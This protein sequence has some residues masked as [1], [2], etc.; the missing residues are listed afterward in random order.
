MGLR[1]DIINKPKRLNL[2]DIKKITPVKPVEPEIKTPLPPQK[3][4]PES[5]II[6]DLIAEF[7]LKPERISPMPEPMPVSAIRLQD[8]I[9]QERGLSFAER[10]SLR[11]MAKELMRPGVGYPRGFLVNKIKEENRVTTA[12]A[13]G[14]LDLH[15]I[16]RTVEIYFGDYYLYQTYRTN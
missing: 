1:V 14:G 8:R 5:S 10:V 11:E 16:A 12:Q 13:E 6:S 3:H 7:N 9:N 4:S 15:L 2:G